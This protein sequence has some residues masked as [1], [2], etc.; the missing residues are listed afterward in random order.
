M[1]TNRKASGLYPLANLHSPYA[2][3]ANSKPVYRNYEIFAATRL[4]LTELSEYLLQQE[5]LAYK[6]GLTTQELN[7]EVL[8]IINCVR[9]HY[10]NNHGLP[11]RPKHH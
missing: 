2:F 11:R 7:K 6:A 3:Q 10:G 5:R 1:P 9:S 4:Y 8:A